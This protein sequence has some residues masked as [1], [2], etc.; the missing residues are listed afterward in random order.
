MAGPCVRHDFGS[1]AAEALHFYEHAKFSIAEVSERR[2][3]T[4]QEWATLTG[5]AANLALCEQLV[6]QNMA[7]G[8]DGDPIFE[9][10]SLTLALFMERNREAT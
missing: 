6:V 4:P 3:V 1:L 5:A 9:V 7:L 2:S 10:M 8:S